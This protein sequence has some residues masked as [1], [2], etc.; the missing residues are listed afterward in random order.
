MQLE[1]EDN[2]RLRHDKS[3]LTL[4]LKADYE[5][6]RIIAVWRNGDWHVNANSKRGWGNM[7]YRMESN[8][9][10]TTPSAL[11]SDHTFTLNLRCTCINVRGC[12]ADV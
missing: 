10:Y 11:S 3:H 8:H 2:R 6:P 5:A 7:I 4:T 12:S 1:C 9:H